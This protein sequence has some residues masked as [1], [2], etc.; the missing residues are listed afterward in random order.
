MS[1]AQY[2]KIDQ[3]FPRIAQQ[4]RERGGREN[5]EE[6]EERRRIEPERQQIWEKTGGRGRNVSR[7]V[8]CLELQLF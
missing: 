4:E 5:E 8:R 3:A 7:P 6:E 1:V 2:H